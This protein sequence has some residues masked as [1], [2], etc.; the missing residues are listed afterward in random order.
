MKYICTFSD[1][2]SFASERIGKIAWEIATAKPQSLGF[3]LTPKACKRFYEK[4]RTIPRDMRNEI[5]TT[6]KKLCSA[7]KRKIGKDTTLS[8]YCSP[9]IRLPGII[10][11]MLGIGLNDTLLKNMWGSKA[12]HGALLTYANQIK[13][14]A[15][16]IMQF[17]S[18]GFCKIEDNAKENYGVTAFAKLSDGDLL[19][20]CNSLKH[21]YKKQSGED[22]PDDPIDL[23]T[24]ILTAAFHSMDNPRAAVYRKLNGISEL[25]A[26][27]I[28]VQLTDAVSGKPSIT[29]SAPSEGEYEIETSDTQFDKANVNKASTAS[30]SP[31]S[32]SESK[33]EFRRVKMK[34]GDLYEGYYKNGKRNGKGKYSF[35]NGDYY[36]GD[37]VDGLFHG[38][39]RYVF[40]NGDFYEGPYKDDCFHGVGIYTFTNGERREVT[41]EMGKKIKERKLPAESIN[42]GQKAV[43][44]FIS[45]LDAL[46]ADEESDDAEDESNDEMENITVFE[47]LKEKLFN[48]SLFK[49]WRDG[50]IGNSGN[51]I[52]AFFD[53]MHNSFG[54][55]DY[56]DAIDWF[57]I[58]TG[59]DYD[60]LTKWMNEKIGS[61][62]N[63]SFEDFLRTG[64]DFAS[65]Q[66]GIADRIPLMA[67]LCFFLWK[68]F[69]KEGSW[70]TYLIKMYYV[71]G[72]YDDSDG[73]FI[74]A[75]CRFKTRGD[76]FESA[77][78]AD[79][80]DSMDEFFAENFDGMFEELLVAG[81][82]P[83]ADGKMSMVNYAFLEEMDGNEDED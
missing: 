4:D 74:N 14:F 5:A 23:L 7:G 31:S 52:E 6:L 63:R 43:E 20:L 17:P 51:Y 48:P 39:G 40:A 35:T 81:K 82:M 68:H 12:A 22:Y 44:A 38:H 56:A 46:Y 72:E 29:K 16:D 66:K 9:E 54:E 47:E 79:N 28:A 26:M 67:N 45:G 70:L 55:G 36:E 77:L 18:S 41:Y 50:Y 3:I 71:T 64:L 25:P 30:T 76:I 24:R 73:P 78:G 33:A 1:S 13:T 75:I 2:E 61:I 57:A 11:T 59:T 49:D 37:F 19:S 27:S 83:S 32:N 15:C 34:S 53:A 58:M 62:G 65:R 60:E 69:D 42:P 80:A 21:E 10:P 8:V